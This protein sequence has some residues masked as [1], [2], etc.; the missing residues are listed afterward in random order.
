[1]PDLAQDTV[2]PVA[3]SDRNLTIVQAMREA[4][5]EEMRR[6]P[7]VF[8]VGEDVRIGGVFLLTL[9]LVDEFGVERIIDTPISEAGFTGLGVGA[10]IE[11]MRP[12]VDFQYG[13]FVF[14]AMD[15]LIQQASKLR[16]MSG[17]QVK[18]PL[19][20]HLPTGAS[21]RGAQ[22]CNP[23]EGFCYS[24]PGI[25]LVTPSSPYDAK[26]LFKSAIRDDNVVLFCVHKHL[27]GSKG[28]P[29]AESSISREH[30]PHEEYTIPLGTAAVK[31]PG[32]QVTV[33]AN[34]LMLHRTLNVATELEKDGLSVEVIDP[35]CLIPFDLETIVASVQ[36]TGRL[37]IVEENHERGGWGA[38]LAA[39]VSR[40]AF[41]Y[42]DQPV[43]R[44]S[45]PDVPIPFSP[46]LEAL[47]VPDEMRIRE[48]VLAI[49]GDG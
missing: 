42:L 2:T 46:P 26:G 47:L 40:E 19:V 22:H 17:G 11:G 25:K 44:L 43:R 12:V 5:V 9:N 32:E 7:E 14:T 15:Q 21:G 27:Y 41:G 45:T 28:R 33:V 24:I 4:L 29:L 38:Q 18:V 39:D 34:M 30:V 13:D 48:E 37:L 20:L 3:G 6:D 1:M 36:K 16:Y 10:A 49:A 23:I 8:V 35:R 31:Q